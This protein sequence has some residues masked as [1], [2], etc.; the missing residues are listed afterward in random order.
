MDR[1][2]VDM[3]ARARI[4]PGCPGGSVHR[5]AAR[6]SR[7]P[8]RSRTPPS[9]WSLDPLATTAACKGAV[10]PCRVGMCR[11]DLASGLRS[12]VLAYCYLSL[13]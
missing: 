4:A 5:L 3:D 9:S 13:D 10:Q 7:G 6:A 1:I 11:A 12:P 8:E 2:G